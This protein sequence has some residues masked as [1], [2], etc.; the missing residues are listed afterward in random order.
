[1]PAARTRWLDPADPFGLEAASSEIARQVIAA[2]LDFTIGRLKS[3]GS[4][5]A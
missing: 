2:A 1:L 5:G 4:G 3:K